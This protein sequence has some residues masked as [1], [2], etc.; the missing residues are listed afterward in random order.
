MPLPLSAVAFWSQWPHTQGW[1]LQGGRTTEV[2][3]PG[4]PGWH[5]Q[6]AQRGTGATHCRDAAEPPRAQRTCCSHYTIFPP[7]DRRNGSE[8][9]VPSH[10]STWGSLFCSLCCSTLHS[11]QHQGF[12]RQ[13]GH[14]AQEAPTFFPKTPQ[15]PKFLWQVYLSQSCI[16]YHMY[17][18]SST[19]VHIFFRAL[20]GL[21][22]L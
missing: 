7:K 21:P 9:A 17:L 15:I 12:Q 1:P 4:A 14:R 13:T 11:L 19:C 10:S 6:D 3:S 20:I 22:G 2:T 5:S 8:P 18:R 16:I